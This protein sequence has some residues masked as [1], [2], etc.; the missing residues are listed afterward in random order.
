M[1]RQRTGKGRERDGQEPSHLIA[2]KCT[3]VTA[4][5]L[6][7]NDNGNG[8]YFFPSSRQAA[9]CPSMLDRVHI[10][11]C[12][13]HTGQSV[14]EHSKTC[15]VCTKG[16][17][18]ANTERAVG[19]TIIQAAENNCIIFLLKTTWLPVVNTLRMQHDKA[20]WAEKTPMRWSGS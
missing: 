7:A 9:V 18:T 16:G 14:Q 19:F 5:C 2:L 15:T 3:P 10:H 4:K 11:M 6:S 12:R 8:D 1:D 13:G 20:S 17:E